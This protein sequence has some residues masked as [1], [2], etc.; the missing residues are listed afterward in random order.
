MTAQ[1]SVSS[2]A[3]DY[4]QFLQSK[5]C[6]SPDS[7]FEVEDSD[8]HPVLKPFQRAVVRWALRGGRRLLAESFGLGKTL[9]QIEILRITVARFGGLGLIVLPLGVRQEFHNDAKLVGVKF[10][11]VRTNEELDA[12][13][14]EG[15][16]LFLTNYESV[17]DGK[18]DPSRFIV[19]SLDEGDCLRGSG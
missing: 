3:L 4:H 10:A 1:P 2:P 6:L 8:V 13:V 17:R 12:A 11:F 15:Y 19:V 14:A 18:L 5:I 7:G 9:Q 16:Q